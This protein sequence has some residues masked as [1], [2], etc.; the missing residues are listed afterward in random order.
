MVAQVPDAVR[1]HTMRRVMWR[2]VPLLMLCYVVNYLDRTNIGFAK[3][4]LEKTFGMSAAQYGFAAGVFF[5][6]YV[7]AEVPSNMIMARVGV[8]IWLTRI[9]VTWGIVET[10]MAFSPN[11]EMVYVMRFLLGIAEAGLFPGILVYLARWCPN[12][13][14]TRVIATFMVTI[15]LA[16]TIGGPLNGWILSGMDHVF[17]LEGWRWVFVLGGIPAILL[18]VVFFTTVTERPSDARWLRAAEREWLTSTLADEERERGAAGPSTHRAVFRDR[19]VLVLAVVYF[20]VQCGAYPLA[21]WLPSVI[22]G[23]GHS[24]TTVQVG[25]LAAVPFLAAAVAMFVTGRRVRRTDS[26]RPVV[27]ALLV[28]VLMFTVSAAGLGTPALAFGAITV[29]TMAAETAKPLFWSLPTAF[30]AGVGA[31]SGVALINSLGNAAGFLSPF[32]VGWIQQVSG[33]N[34]GL[35]IGVMASANVLAVLVIGGLWWSRRRARGA[36]EAAGVPGPGAGR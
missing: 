14:R 28:S 11:V 26:A 9:M 4:G 15:P 19:R 35:S 3:F 1:A 16:G 22:K 27:L 20:L 32:A 10:I 8:R 30:L 29:A 33:G 34:T 17:G 7:L 6:G 5:V 25:W 31:A 18:G 21:Y 13:E 24:L 23:V 36:P 2:I 12:R